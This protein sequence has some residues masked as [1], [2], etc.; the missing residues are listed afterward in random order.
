M[1]STS[2]P[3]LGSDAPAE[4]PHADVAE[5]LAGPVDASP[6]PGAAS[7]D[8]AAPAL[9]TAPIADPT[10][11]PI[12]LA[13]PA[14]AAL[15]EPAPLPLAVPAA[16]GDVASAAPPGLSPAE[17]AQRLKSLF[18]ALFGGAPKPLKLR[19]QSDIQQRAPGEF[20]RRSLS[21]FLHRHTGSTGYLMAITRL[22]QRHDLDGVAVEP[23]NEEH[24]TAAATELARRRGN[25][26][27]RRELE[28]TQR[29][30]RAGLLR[31]HETTTLTRANFCV[32]KG[33]DPDQ[34]DELLALAR[35]EADE[36]A[37]QRPPAFERPQQ[38]QRPQPQR[39]NQAPRRGPRPPRG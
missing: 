18:P 16:G 31:D 26:E 10:A 39:P 34:L 8:A 33:V 38:P 24:R 27:E 35:R 37:R 3:E 22:G 1:S 6:P 23:V 28:Q 30:N 21:A 13:G 20:T 17:V 29:H 25:Q 11:D 12:D 32:L 14:D 7:P 36:A 5:T 4:R 2:L 9:P 15:A 19:I